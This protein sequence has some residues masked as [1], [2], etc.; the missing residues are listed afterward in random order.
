MSNMKASNSFSSSPGQDPV[1]RVFRNSYLI[2]TA[3]P[4]GKAGV[5]GKALKSRVSGMQ[6]NGGGE[7]ML[8]L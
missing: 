8:Q 2:F 6:E 7:R 3:K 1:R 5:F 4:G